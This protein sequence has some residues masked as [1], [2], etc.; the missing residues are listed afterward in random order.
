MTTKTKVKTTVLQQD[1]TVCLAHI[2]VTVNS[3]E[4]IRCLHGA[5]ELDFLLVV[6]FSSTHGFQFMVYNG[7]PCFYFCPASGERKRENEKHLPFPL[8]TQL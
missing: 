1:R 8:G 4:L 7:T 2:I 5:E 3:L 6:L